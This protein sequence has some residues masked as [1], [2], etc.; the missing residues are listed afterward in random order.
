MSAAQLAAS[1]AAAGV[2][3]YEV[4]RLMPVSTVRWHRIE[5]GIVE[6]TPQELADFERFVLRR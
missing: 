6:P 4:P 3:L 5:Q 1:R 2:T